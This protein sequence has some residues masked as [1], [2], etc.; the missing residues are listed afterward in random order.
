MPKIILQAGHEG[1]TSG[2]TGAPNEKGFNVDIANQVR[3]ILVGKGFEVRRVNADPKSTETAGD[4]DLFLSIHYDADVYGTGGYFVD[5]PEPSTDGATQRSQEIAKTLSE[6]YGRV[7]AIVNHPERSNRNTRYYYM[8][9]SLSSKTPC[10]IIECGVGMHVPDDH[11]TLH[12]NRPLVAEG[13]SRGICKAFSITYDAPDPFEP[14]DPSSDYKKIISELQTKMVEMAQFYE[15]EKSVKDEQ[16]KTLETAL[17]SL[18]DTEHTWEDQA[19]AYQRKLKAVVAEFA[20]VGVQLSAE[21]DEGLLASEIS[22]CLVSVSETTTAMEIAT[23]QLKQADA[24]IA[25]LE[26]QIEDLKRKDP[27]FRT[28]NLPGFIIKFYKR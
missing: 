23:E 2:A 18:Q 6:E 13:I 27:A 10:V 25:K 1:R 17:K 3:D 5:F 9:K 11:T 28:V 16:I 19:D 24:M 15:K 20:K 4:W 22:N 12:F 21:S 8:W 26:K 7:T 14:V